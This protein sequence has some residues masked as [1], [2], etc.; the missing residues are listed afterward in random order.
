[1]RTGGRVVTVD[2][3]TRTG[4]S[5]VQSVWDFDEASGQDRDRFGGKGANLAVMT[6]LGLPVPPGFIIET[7]ACRAYLKE[8]RLPD[9]LLDEVDSHLRRLEE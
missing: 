4:G 9:G 8:E 7:E 2:P 5:R 3:T 1:L 6:Q